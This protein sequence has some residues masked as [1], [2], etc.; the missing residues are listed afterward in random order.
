MARMELAGICLPARTVS[1]D[2]Y[3]FLPLGVNEL[4]LAL[5]DICGKGIS[6]AL[7]MTNLQATLR[8]KLG[9]VGHENRMAAERLP[10]WSRG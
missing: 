7:L 2:Y 3:D 8:S 9:T 10:N 1:G 6:A 5:G 4:G